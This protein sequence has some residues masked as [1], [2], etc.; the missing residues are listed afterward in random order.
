MRNF[1][2]N[3]LSSYE[4]EETGRRGIQ[5]LIPNDFIPARDVPQSYKAE[6]SRLHPLEDSTNQGLSPA[7]CH[8]RG[9]DC[10]LLHPSRRA[11]W[12][13]SFEWLFQIEDH[14]PRSQD[15]ASRP[16]RQ[17]P[18]IGGLAQ[19]LTPVIS[20][21]AAVPALVVFGPWGHPAICNP[22]DSG[23]WHIACENRSG[24]RRFGKDSRHITCRIIAA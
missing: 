9:A 2:Q 12:I 18:L 13:Y 23:S 4:G 1:R 21:G 7:I 17:L 20:R 11:G 8:G 22:L 19:Q 16:L 3:R 5:R 10:P 6:P 24:D 15:Q 14:Q